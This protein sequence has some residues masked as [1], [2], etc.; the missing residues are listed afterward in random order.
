MYLCVCICVCVSVC[1][2]VCACLCCVSVS[3]CVYVLVDWCLFE[4]RRIEYKSVNDEYLGGR[5]L[6]GT[7]IFAC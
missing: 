2:F 1:V 7:W 3:V 5:S 4:C 6:E